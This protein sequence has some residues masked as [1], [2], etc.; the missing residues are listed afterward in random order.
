MELDLPFRESPWGQSGDQIGRA[1][2]R[3]QEEQLVAGGEAGCS[4][5]TEGEQFRDIPEAAS[6]GLVTSSG[7][8]SQ[9]KGAPGP[10]LGLGRAVLESV[11]LV[12][13]YIYLISYCCCFQEL[14]LDFIIKLIKNTFFGKKKKRQRAAF[15][16]NFLGNFLRKW[17]RACCCPGCGRDGK[18]LEPSRRDRGP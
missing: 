14:R 13:I 9:G 4:P 1:P 5:E 2:G 8:G 16:A 11:I 17:E 6:G 12:L 10:L 18:D 7:G 15:T 3:R